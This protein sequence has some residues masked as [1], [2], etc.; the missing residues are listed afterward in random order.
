MF[1]SL[2]PDITDGNG[3]RSLPVQTSTRCSFQHRD[4]EAT[5]NS[6]GRPYVRD[7]SRRAASR[8][9]VFPFVGTATSI[10]PIMISVVDEY[11]TWTVI[12]E[13]AP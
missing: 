11:G 3:N 2:F 4:T 12:D 9:P 7:C 1:R 8:F 6:R 13:R 5:E 10:N